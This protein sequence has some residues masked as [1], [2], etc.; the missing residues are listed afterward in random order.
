MK[1]DQ[2]SNYQSS[3]FLTGFITG[4]LTFSIIL[5]LLG[6]KS[7]RKLLLELIQIAEELDKNHIEEKGK[8]SH[9]KKFQL[10][11]EFDSKT[12]KT[13]LY[14]LQSIIPDREKIEKYF[15]K[16]GKLLK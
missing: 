7:G 14:K 3:G 6:T 9:E 16:D 12:I 5:F 10:K 8:K 13:V 1:N 2:K 15:A 4:S 11:D